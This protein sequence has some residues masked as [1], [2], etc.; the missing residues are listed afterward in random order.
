MRRYAVI[1][2][3]HGNRWALER[4]LDD[5]MRKGI[6]CIINL[7]D[8]LYGPLDPKGTAEILIRMNLLS[9][10][11][12]EDRI[13]ISS[14]SSESSPTMQYVQQSLEQKHF[15][16]LHQL[17]STRIVDGNL[18]A[19][20]AS[21]HSDTQ[22]FFWD[23][24]HDGVVM[25]GREVMSRIV[26]NTGCSILLCGHDHIP[27]SVQLQNNLLAVDPGS[28]G[29]PAYADE[30]PHPHV[31]QTGSP[32]A[33]YAVVI[34]DNGKWIVEHIRLEYDWEAAAVKAAENGR[35]DWASWL[36]TGI[37]SLD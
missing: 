7:G 16:W 26:E 31:M 21:P 23:V 28:V 6:E 27:R 12:N 25:R 18:H 36:R 8:S 9:V 4:L 22:Y 29:L 37:A 2:D 34:E 5:T 11:G 14:D 35:Q 10:L 15:E 20:H 24:R 33:R 17:P 1:S 30:L 13:I 19:C 32:H 3:I